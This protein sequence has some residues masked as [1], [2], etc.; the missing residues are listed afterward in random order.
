MFAEKLRAVY[1]HA[2]LT[3]DPDGQEKRI[4]LSAGITLLSERDHG[5]LTEMREEKGK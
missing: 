4:R 5:L 3:P 2:Q 1:D